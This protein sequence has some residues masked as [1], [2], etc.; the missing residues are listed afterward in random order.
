MVSKLLNQLLECMGTL[1]IVSIDGKSAFPLRTDNQS[2]E[3]LRLRDCSLQLSQ[4][5][6]ASRDTF[7]YPDGI[8]DVH[9]ECQ[10]YE[11]CVS[12][13]RELDTGYSPTPPQK[14]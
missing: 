9:E 10:D 8:E 2:V 1:W 13:W 6:L 12:T 7:P 11:G 3:F 4:F 5:E 14:M